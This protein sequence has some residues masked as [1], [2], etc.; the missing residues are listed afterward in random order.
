MPAT[1][2]TIFAIGEGRRFDAVPGHVVRELSNATS[3]VNASLGAE[4]LAEL[5][6]VTTSR[7]N[8]LGWVLF[9]IANALLACKM[10][11]KKQAL[12]ISKREGAN[13][14][15]ARPSPLS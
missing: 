8:T 5:T 7:H 15:P 4:Y 10:T 3:A 11:A 14:Q 2:L 6:P 12:P 9:S 1:P 13:V